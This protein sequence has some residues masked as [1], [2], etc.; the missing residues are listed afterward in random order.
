MPLSSYRSEC[1]GRWRKSI[2]LEI[3][4]KKAWIFYQL[5]LCSLEMKIAGAKRR[6]RVACLVIAATRLSKQLSTCDWKCI[7]KAL[8]SK[9]VAVWGPTTRT[10]IPVACSLGGK[11]S[12]KQL[13]TA[14]GALA[15]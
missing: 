7:T 2:V 3:Y 11:R 4:L 1:Y 13:T 15:I 10:G 9:P 6:A 8:T 5:D 14:L 12:H